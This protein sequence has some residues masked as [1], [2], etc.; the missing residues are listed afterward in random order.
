MLNEKFWC[1]VVTGTILG[2]LLMDSSKDVHKAF[3]KGKDVV[4]TIIEPENQSNKD[5]VKIIIEPIDEVI[6]VNHPQKKK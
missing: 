4:Q 6:D 2:M 3:E 5:A 1:G